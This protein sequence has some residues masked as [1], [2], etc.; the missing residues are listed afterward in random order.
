V[1]SPKSRERLKA[2][3]LRDAVEDNLDAIHNRLPLPRRPGRRLLRLW[4]QRVWRA[5]FPV[6]VV[7]A[8]AGLANWPTVP[9]AGAAHPA[10]LHA[11]VVPRGAPHTWLPSQRIH[12]DV[13]ALMVRRV[14]IDAGHGGDDLGTSSAGGLKEKDLTLD[15]ATRVRQALTTRGFEPILTR[16]TDIRLSLEQRAAAANGGQGD[17][18]VSIHLNSLEPSSVR[19]IETYY[20]G[21]S[22]GLALD[23]AAA[24]NLHSEYSLSNLRLL[25]EK[26]YTDVRRDESRR[27]ATS[28][29]RA[30]VRTM[31]KTEPVLTDRGVKMAPFVV[32]AATEMPAILVEV[33][34][35]S[36]KDSAERLA[37]P[38]YRQTIAEALVSGIEIFA[39][40]SRR[41][42]VA[43]RTAT[44]GS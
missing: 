19:G 6:A 2:Q 5:A 35:L 27:L 15:I 22:G 25:L 17:I 34:C 13:L 12:P 4:S 29:Q 8:S 23:A 30:L 21:P 33:S 9:Q 20:L 26:I 40:E 11:Q 39:H 7:V 31:R 24:E 43:E 38:E 3:I 14:V 1:S 28:V 16:T 10:A 37:K 32:L 41:L 36:N 42:N 18:F 44:S